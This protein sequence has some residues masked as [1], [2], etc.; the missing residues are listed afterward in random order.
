MKENKFLRDLVHNARECV[1]FRIKHH[2]LI[3]IKEKDLDMYFDSEIFANFHANL[4]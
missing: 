3:D 2:Q 4:R 1:Q